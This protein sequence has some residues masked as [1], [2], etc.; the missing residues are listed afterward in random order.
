MV[1]KDGPVEASGKAHDGAAAAEELLARL[2]RKLVRDHARVLDLF[3]RWDTSGDGAVDRD[4]FR[5]RM[6]SEMGYDGSECDAL[7]ASF[8]VDASGHIEYSE[9]YQH[10]RRRYQKEAPEAKRVDANQNAPMPQTI[11]EPSS[12]PPAPV[13]RSSEGTGAANAVSSASPPQI[14]LR[15][16]PS[17]PPAAKAG[18]HSAT[19]SA[20]T[21]SA[22]STARSSLDRAKVDSVSRARAEAALAAVE[23]AARAEQSAALLSPLRSGAEQEAHASE[24]ATAGVAGAAG[25]V[26]EA[27]A[28]VE[29]RPV[30]SVL[31][32]APLERLPR[33]AEEDGHGDLA[34][35]SASSTDRSAP[36][37]SASSTARGRYAFRK[38]V[39]AS[40][41]SLL[42]GKLTAVE[43]SAE[44]E[45]TEVELS[46]ERP[47]PPP[48]PPLLMQQDPEQQLGLGLVSVPRHGLE[49]QLPQPDELRRPEEG[50]ADSSSSWNGEQAVQCAPPRSI[51]PLHEACSFGR[52]ALV[53]RL[54]REGADVDEVVPGVRESPL[55]AAV[56][57]GH[58]DCIKLLLSAKADVDAASA[59]GLTALHLA[60]GANDLACAKLLV[61]AKASLIFGEG[62]DGTAALV[63]VLHTACA[64]GH[65]QSA[66]MLLE[67][68]AKPDVTLPEDGSTALHVAAEQG[69]VRLVHCLV[70]RRA[71]LDVRMHGGH[72]PLMTAIE[73]GHVE[74]ARKLLDAG[75]SVDVATSGEAGGATPLSV[76]IRARQAACVAELVGRMVRSGG[77]CEQRVADADGTL[78]T[79]LELA[80]ILGHDECLLELIGAPGLQLQSL[81]TALRLAERRGEAQ[82]VLMLSKAR[83]L[84][85]AQ[86]K[87]WGGLDDSVGL[88]PEL[89]ER[90]K[91]EWMAGV[92]AAEEAMRLFKLM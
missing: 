67:A 34:A 14:G 75:A 49:Q 80:C 51:P 71:S 11:A 57:N 46:L 25:E 3:R 9:L 83:E 73:A 74:C 30:A 6:V 5:R 53:K 17:P 22:S 54:L 72:T 64:A 63:P 36:T 70:E 19:P 86:E 90:L 52:T 28:S 47:P 65:W 7:F 23:A 45:A 69:S 43:E 76:A 18:G 16:P 12:S 8:D 87:S 82:C 77:S 33:A 38:E 10:L 92:L 66:K 41:A 62:G 48:Q 44:E 81:E 39:D 84:W 78:R 20:R 50:A 40:L 55:H 42:S 31:P 13:Q 68:G 24:P 85:V 1:S 79:P 37:S 32:T 29:E 56:L 15:M 91:G 21:P 26:S 89:A 2:S 60:V 59:D 27:A 58:A 88:A 35:P 4:E 61:G